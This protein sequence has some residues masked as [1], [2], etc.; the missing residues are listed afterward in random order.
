M[1][2]IA[3]VYKQCGEGRRQE[4]VLIWGLIRGLF[5]L[6]PK[7]SQ[8]IVTRGFDNREI[9]TDPETLLDNGDNLRLRCAKCHNTARQ[10][11]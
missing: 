11:H 6:L 8:K 3:R 2:G 4:F 1:R 5:T 7:N 9:L 10:N